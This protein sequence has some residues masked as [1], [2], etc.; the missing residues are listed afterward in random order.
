M[1][2]DAIR[3]GRLM[4]NF[5]NTPIT[6]LITFDTLIAGLIGWYGAK[7]YGADTKTKI[8]VTAIVI[9]LN[10]VLHHY[11]RMKTAMG[12]FLGL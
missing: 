2:I 10:A 8:V 11:L 1:D 12:K 4:H 3:D 7:W 9:L 5:H 6:H